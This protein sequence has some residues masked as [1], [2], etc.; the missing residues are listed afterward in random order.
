MHALA[1]NDFFYLHAGS[2]FEMKLVLW[3]D[4]AVEFDGDAVYDIGQEHHVV[5]IF[6]G[7]LV[8]SY[9]G[10]YHAE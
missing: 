3:G 7:L 6:V 1:F 9:K 5:V 8:K 4:G 2:G 10:C